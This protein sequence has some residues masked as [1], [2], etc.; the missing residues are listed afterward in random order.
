MNKLT[1]R[2]VLIT[3]A[4]VAGSAALMARAR[5]AL[6][7]H[8]HQHQGQQPQ[9]Q[10]QQAPSQGK[11]ARDTARDNRPVVRGARTPYTPVIAPNVSTLPWKEVAGVKVFHLVAQSLQ[12]QFADGLEVTCWG[13]NGS[14]PGPLIEAVEGDRCRFYVTNRLPEVTTVHW[15]GVHLPNGMDGVGGLTQAVIEPGQTFV[16][17]FELGRAGTFMY[18]PHFDEMT[19]IALGMTGMIVVHPRRRPRQRRRVR[20]YSLMLHEWL[21][22]AGTSRPD[23]LAMTD[24]NV[25]TINGKAFPGTDPLLAETGDL[26][27]IRFG[28]LSPMEHHPMHLHGHSFQVVE[29]DGGP[30]PPSAR[31]L[32]TT[33]LVPVGTAQVIEFVADAPGDW[34][35]HC[36]MTHHMMNQMG[37]DVPNLIGADPGRIDAK[38]HPLLPGY[39][40]MGENGMAGMGEMNMP[41]PRNSIPMKGKPGPFG[42]IDMGGMFT[43]LKVRDRLQG[44]GD[45]G[46]YQHP[47]GTVARPATAAELHKDGIEIE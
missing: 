40:T 22:P 20:D 26:V 42:Y 3:G 12:R 4:T 44:Q 46:W 23:P 13:Y 16:Y 43:I 11:P 21:I 14:S 34:A 41:M 45:P 25:L 36:H 1:R 47:P 5:D 10:P 24:F 18:H 38:V 2:D 17:E 8:D 6:G 27:R 35:L 31:R 28:N 7:Q 32:E 39:M 15:H 29:T 9:P 33:V 19:Q 30:V 37:H